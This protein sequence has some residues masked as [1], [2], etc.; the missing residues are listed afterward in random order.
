[1]AHN[2]NI[3]CINQCTE[4]EGPGKRFAIWF[5]GCDK[6]CAGCCNPELFEV[7]P[8]HIL[9][10][11]EV[12]KI[13]VDA[14]DNFKIEG[15]TY[16]GGEPT[17]QNGL[18]KLSKEIKKLGLGVILLTGNKFE[19]LDIDLISAVDLI[20]DGQFEI[21]KPDNDR[22]LIGSTNQN[23]IFITERY[24]NFKNWFYDYRP[25]RI[26]INIGTEL[27]LTGDKVL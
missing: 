9:S 21:D 26:E 1:M 13:I 4:A 16:L 22:N 10:L 19:S 27:F 3:A 18:L 17:L 23:I 8:A 24:K 5:Q 6:K 11:D 20:I 15:V 12:L 7:K 2:F 14:K 25:K